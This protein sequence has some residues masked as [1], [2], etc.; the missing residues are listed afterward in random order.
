[1]GVG[2]DSV[3]SVGR[4][5][6]LAEARA[7]RTL[8]GLS[9]EEALKLVTSGAARAL[10]LEGEVGALR[11]GLWGDVAV[12]WIDRTDDAGQALE[13]ALASGPDDVEETTIGG[14]VLYRR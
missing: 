13:A 12:V 14:C 7:A 9:A 8:A 3:A 10:G 11:P 2:T 1:M 4:L 6:L 5:D